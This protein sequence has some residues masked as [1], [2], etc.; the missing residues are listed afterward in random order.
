MI[1]AISD[2]GAKPFEADEGAGR[3]AILITTQ[4][5]PRAVYAPAGTVTVTKPSAEVIESEP[6]ESEFASTGGG[7][8]EEPCHTVKWR[9]NEDDLPEPSWSVPESTWRPVARAP[10]L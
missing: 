4:S 2:A 1:S 6:P 7:G 10:V 8:P 3:V 5:S 9:R